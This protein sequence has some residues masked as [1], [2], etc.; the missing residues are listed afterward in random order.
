MD[1]YAETRGIGEINPDISATWQQSTGYTTDAAGNRTP[2]YNTQNVTIQ[3]QALS[4]DDLQV[5]GYYQM[6][7]VYRCVYMYGDVVGLVRA[8][9][10][11]GDL[12]TFAQDP[13]KAPQVWKVVKVF[14]TWRDW[15]RLAVCLQ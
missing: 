10:K 8:D 3:V 1:L 11:G 4:G 9:E 13:S 12:L 7:G 15:C 6:E 5:L 14:E 2:T